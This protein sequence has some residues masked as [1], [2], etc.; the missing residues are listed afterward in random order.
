MMTFT[1][2]LCLAG[3][4][5]AF[6]LGLAHAACAQSDY[7]SRPVKIVVPF[8]AGGGVDILARVV[9]QH[10]GERLGQPVVVENRA[11]AG[12]TPGVQF[13]AQAEPDGY[14]LVMATTGTHTINPALF[15][16]L[17]YDPIKGFEP[18]TLVASVPNLLVVN[19]AVPAQTVKELVALAKAKPGELNFG[20]FGPGTSNHLSG[21]LLKHLA[22]LDITHVPYRKAPEGVVDLIEGRIQMLFVNMPLGLPHVKAGK[23]RALAVSG[24]Q[25]SAMVPELPTMSEAGVDDF[26]VESWYGLLAPAGTPKPIISRLHDE[27]KVVLARPAVQEFFA[28]QGA[29]TL[30]ST[31]AE[32][33]AM[34]KAEIPRWKKIIE[35]SGVPVN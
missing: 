13:V 20:S 18:I 4:T 34:I 12:G 30:T 27:V 8:A 15:S 3:I 19:P 32:L 1:R 6:V 17:P 29:E 11:G 22:K 35:I 26:V 2:R 9:A 16:T 24:A 10:L 21:E 7:P 33:T 28:K 14:T 23:M 5:G 31:P 25:R